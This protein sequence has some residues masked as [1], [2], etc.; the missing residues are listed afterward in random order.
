M[1][2]DISRL[3]VSERLL[4]V[5]E[6]WD[7]IAGTPEALPVTP[8]QQDELDRRIEAE[9]TDPEGV[10]SWQDVKAKIKSR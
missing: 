1:I 5:D 2:A 10:A 7:S 8:E 6:I 4:L 3:S 9:K